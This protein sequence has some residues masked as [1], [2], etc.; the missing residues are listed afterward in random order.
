VTDTGEPRNDSAPVHKPRL[1]FTYK[2]NYYY[3]YY[4]Y[5]CTTQWRRSQVKSGG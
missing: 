1:M 4:Y 5:T 3:Y 2:I